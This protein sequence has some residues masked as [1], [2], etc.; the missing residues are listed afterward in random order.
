MYN[1]RS[2]LVN[3]FYVSSGKNRLSYVTYFSEITSRSDFVDYLED[4][5]S[6]LY[7]SKDSK[8]VPHNFF[9]KKCIFLGDPLLIKFETKNNIGG[10]PDKYYMDYN[11]NTMA[12]YDLKDAK[13]HIYPWGRFKSREKLGLTYNLEGYLSDYSEGGYYLELGQETTPLEN[14]RIKLSR[15]SEF[16]KT[17]TLAANFVVGGY[18]LDIDYFFSINLAIEKTLSGGY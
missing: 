13:G 7:V 2:S 6:N 9:A 1:L 5:T 8:K 10:N 16:L 12:S 18:I 17:N 15:I 4:M 11:V 3:L 14:V